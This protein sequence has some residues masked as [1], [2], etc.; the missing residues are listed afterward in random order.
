MFQTENEDPKYSAV[1]GMGVCLCVIMGYYGLG[2]FYVH[3]GLQGFSSPSSLLI[4]KQQETTIHSQ[5]LVQSKEV[6]FV[7]K[8]IGFWWHRVLAGFYCIIR[9]WI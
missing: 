1:L 4:R 6:F 5:Q 3:F 2:F 9:L 7:L 8:A